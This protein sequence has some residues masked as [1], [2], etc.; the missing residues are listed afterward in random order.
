MNTDLA[1]ARA[2]T[3]RPIAEIA[4]KLDIPAEALEPYGRFKAKVGFD[5]LRE[6]EARPD[7][8]VVLVTGISPTP[9]GEGKTTTTVGLGDALNRIG[10]RAAICLRE[11]SLGPSFGQKGGAA[12]G[13]HSQVAPMEEINLHFT[14][15][16]HAITA[17]NNLLAALIDNH[18][19]WGNALGI[20][21][22][23]ITWRRAMDMNDRALRGMVVGLGGVGQ[24]LRARG[25]VRHHRGLRGDGGVLPVARPGRSAGAARPHRDRPDARRPPA[26]RARPEG[27]RRHGGAAARRAATQPGA[28][29]GGIPRLRARRPVRQYRARL[30]FGDGDEAGDEAGRCGGDR[31][32][33]RRR[34][35]GGEVPRH[36]VPPR[37]A[38]PFGGGGGGHGAGAED[39]RRRGAIGS[40]AGGCRRGRTRG[41][42]PGA[43]RGEPGQ[44]RPARCWWR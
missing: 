24:R 16:F 36:Q 11:P 6:A 7:G 39:A 8:A 21:T 43:A 37:R 15:D 13:G 17:A 35:G 25:W 9:A 3:L 2:T 27:G 42:E 12:G 20:D 18:I 34:P 31:G 5:F 41:R 40:R 23:R 29:A 1:I 28:D 19:Y 44:V 26:D 22:R 10:V 32:G 4:A 30:Q 14:G 38:A 33:L